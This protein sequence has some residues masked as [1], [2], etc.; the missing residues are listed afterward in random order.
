MRPQH[1]VLGILPKRWCA[2]WPRRRD[3]LDT[4][5]GEPTCAATCT[6][7]SDAQ[8]RTLRRCE[9]V[10]RSA[11]R[12]DPIRTS[13]YLRHKDHTVKPWDQTA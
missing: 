6:N 3:P 9:L 2:C 10:G 12:A 13:S 4:K 7:G 5:G 11:S 1:G 8:K